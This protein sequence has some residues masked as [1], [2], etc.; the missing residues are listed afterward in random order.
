MRS[1][2]RSPHSTEQGTDQDWERDYF[3]RQDDRQESR[4]G[5]WRSGNARDSPS[6]RLRQADQGREKEDDGWERVQRRRH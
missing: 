5:D 3:Q 2:R 1:W 6:R 4:G